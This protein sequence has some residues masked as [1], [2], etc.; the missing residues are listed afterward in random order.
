MCG[1]C[2]I[3]NFNNSPV[4]NVQISNM[5]RT[6][7]HRGP[8]DE[9][10]FVKENIGLGFVRLSILDLT[11]S[12]H[13][14]MFDDS[15][16][17]VILFNG[18]VYNFIEI[19]EILQNKG[20]KF[21]SNTDTEVVLK[22]Y[23]EWGEDCL[24][25]FNGMWAFVI[26][27][28][29]KKELFCARD[30]FGIKPFYYFRD[31]NQFIFSSEIT[32][33]LQIKPEL[34]KVNE[35]VV[36]DYLLTNRTNHTENTFFKDIKK[37]QHSSK[38]NIKIQEGSVSVNK[39]YF[40]NNRNSLG[41]TNS[42][43]FKEDFVSSINLQL[44]SD[45]PI[46]LCL[47]GGLDSSSIG[48]TISK[49]I[50]RK[51][52]HSF[53]AVYERGQKGDESE[54]INE[55]NGY[56]DN[57]H[58]THPTINSFMNEMDSF[59]RTLEEPVPGTS[60]Y[61]EFKVMQ[62]AKD[63]CT[64]I[65]NGQGVDEYLAGYHYFIGFLLKQHALELNFFNILQEVYKYHKI[66]GSIYPLR[67]GIFFML[68]P[69]LKKYLLL[70]KNDYLSRTFFNEYSK[71]KQD[72]SLDILYSSKTLKES[73][74][75]HFEYKFEHHLL[76]ADKSG[77][78]FSLETRFPFLDHNIVEKMLNT[79][80]DFIYKNG[81]TKIILRQAM[82][83]VLPDKV[84]NRMDKVGYETPEDEWFRSQMFQKYFLEVT[85]S[86]EFKKRPYFDMDKIRR[87]NS[88]HISGRKNYGQE[89]WKIL[90]LELWLRKFID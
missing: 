9:G 71:Q 35:S 12:G 3:I 39:W 37:L 85:N 66:H 13:Q 83:G 51:D 30:R 33:L 22:S 69:W 72:S 8:D 75:N 23:L 1:I 50:G 59:I 31:D 46:G 28:N 29:E 45:V 67:S 2:G 5:M 24:N 76:W 20:Y 53:S 87:L 18:E 84:K 57:I 43:D 44:R 42:D 25:R 73:F 26:Y 16:R 77:M 61:A 27:N 86:L 32:P 38:I 6:M 40:L 74:L 89:I 14:P 49:T 19:R 79:K 64:V 58:F 62:L 70:K 34:R 68:P 4:D 15:G 10:S 88:E 80:T 82:N 7:K 81:I 48:A 17:I 65:L 78:A 52:I 56:I 41:Y 60:E 47:S 54:F 90:H 11:Y 55:F 63:F 36:F 21:K